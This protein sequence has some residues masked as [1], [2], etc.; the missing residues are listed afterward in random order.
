M[1]TLN[2]KATNGIWY[3][4]S[5]QKCKSSQPRWSQDVDGKKNFGESAENGAK[6]IC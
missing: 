3:V 2:T 4:H 6:V 1:K 5:S